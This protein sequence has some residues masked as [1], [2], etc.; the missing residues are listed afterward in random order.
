MQR[1][2]SNAE[3]ICRRLV[4]LV[5]EGPGGVS[6]TVAEEK[7]Y[8]CDDFLRV[9][10]GVGGLEGEEKD[11]RRI[12]WAGELGKKVRYCSIFRG[13]TSAYVVAYKTTDSL[14]EWNKT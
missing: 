7:R 6:D 1:S 13:F 12:D 2:C 14:I 11:K 10:G 9:S 3:R 8:V 5:E 4:G